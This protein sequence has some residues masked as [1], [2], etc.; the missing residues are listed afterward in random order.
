MLA[1][2][3]ELLVYYEYYIALTHMD[4]R[5]SMINK[6]QI[7]SEFLEKYHDSDT[8]DINLLFK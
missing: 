5:K 1:R 4:I 6:E 7:N 2:Y 3:F 8:Y